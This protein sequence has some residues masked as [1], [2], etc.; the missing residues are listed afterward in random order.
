[1]DAASTF[2]ETGPGE[3]QALRDGAKAAFVIHLV[4]MTTGVSAREIAQGA[5]ARN[6]AA[7]ARWLAMY[8]L[9]TTLG[10][11]LMRVG[12]AFG[13]DRTTVGQVL[14]RIEDWRSDPL[15]EEMLSAL[16]RCVLA[17]PMEAAPRMLALQPTDRE[18]R[19]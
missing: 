8:L 5:R 12:A 6:P 14:G 4:A 19:A 9:H 2:L 7:R 13:R 15:F 3:L 16:E 17:A 18:A 10:V 11:P 1:M